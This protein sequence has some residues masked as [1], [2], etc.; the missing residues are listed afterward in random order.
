M[1]H[2]PRQAVK[3]EHLSSKWTQPSAPPTRRIDPPA[4][5]RDRANEG[6]DTSRNP[7]GVLVVAALFF[8]PGIALL[9]HRGPAMVAHMGGRGVWGRIEIEPESV[10]HGYGVALLIMSL[11]ISSFYFYLR[12]RLRREAL[13]PHCR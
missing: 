10:V 13:H 5:N 9:C 11:A 6:R 4:V 1:R 8:L 3:R 12:G 7:Y 2:Y